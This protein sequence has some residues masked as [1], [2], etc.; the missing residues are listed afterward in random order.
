M[1]VSY[2]AGITRLR[3]EDCSPSVLRL[4]Q[5]LIS[6]NLIVLLPPHRLG[7]NR[8]EALL[9]LHLLLLQHLLVLEKVELLL[10]HALE[11]RCKVLLG[12]GTRVHV[13]RAWTHVGE[14]WA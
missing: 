3:E 11:L 12:S 5:V 2:C 7:C 14:V 4:N 8:P 1:G 6:R 13:C 10:R 9:L